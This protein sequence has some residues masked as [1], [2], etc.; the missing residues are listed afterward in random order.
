VFKEQLYQ[1]LLPEWLSIYDFLNSL[2]SVI[3]DLLR[4]FFCNFRNLLI[5]LEQPV[6][7]MIVPVK[8][9]LTF[10]RII[11]HVV[12]SPDMN[13]SFVF[14]RLAYTVPCPWK[15]CRGPGARWPTGSSRWPCV[16]PYWVSTAAWRE[17]T[18]RRPWIATWKTTAPS[19]SSSGESW[20][21]A[22][23]LWIHHRR[24]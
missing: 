15:P 12:T 3:N 8:L 22:S 1:N 14:S 13:L 20:S 6:T 18:W 9:V 16:S 5:N 7:F 23:E 2:Y 19:T 11:G 4:T 17:S 10:F 24:W 21:R